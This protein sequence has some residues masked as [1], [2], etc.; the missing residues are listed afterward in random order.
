[1]PDIT[2]YKQD[3]ALIVTALHVQKAELRLRAMRTVDDTLLDR[4]RELDTLINKLL[5]REAQNLHPP[6]G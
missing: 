4:I 2:I 6:H 1:M 5:D 3:L